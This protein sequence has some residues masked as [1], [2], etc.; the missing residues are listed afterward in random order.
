[1][2]ITLGALKRKLIYIKEGEIDEGLKDIKNIKQLL[3]K[4]KNRQIFSKEKVSDEQKC[5]D[6]NSN[7]TND[8][9]QYKIK[10]GIINLGENKGTQIAGKNVQNERNYTKLVIIIAVTVIIIVG[11][12]FKYPYVKD[13]I[14]KFLPLLSF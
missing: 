11:I 4:K 6:L 13:V 1:M 5:D 10:I 3:F 2:N 12:I 9:S 8:S 7:L 14:E